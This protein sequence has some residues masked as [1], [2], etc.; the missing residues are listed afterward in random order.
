MNESN[1]TPTEPDLP[2]EDVEVLY[3]KYPVVKEILTKQL[4]KY[5]RLS[6]KYEET[7]MVLRKSEEARR[8][9]YHELKQKE[10]ESED[11]KYRDPNVINVVTI[12]L[13][14]VLADIFFLVVFQL[15]SGVCAKR[16]LKKTYGAM[17]LAQ[18]MCITSLIL[19]IMGFT[20][21]GP[22]KE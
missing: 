8:N 5:K 4:D 10:W 13:T 2:T 21:K 11:S 6:E 19:A 3:T 7:L 18:G 12:K 15:L 22:D 17:K 14:D 1:L 16:Q 20:D 9:I